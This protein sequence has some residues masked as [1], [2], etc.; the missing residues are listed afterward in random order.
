[1]ASVCTNYARSFGACEK[2]SKMFV[3]IDVDSPKYCLASN[4]PENW[5]HLHTQA[6]LVWLHCTQD[7]D[8]AK[9]M[10]SLTPTPTH[11]QVVHS[12]AHNHKHDWTLAQ[13]WTEKPTDFSW[14]TNGGPKRTLAVAQHGFDSR[15]T[16]TTNTRHDRIFNMKLGSRKIV[17]LSLFVCACLTG[18]AHDTCG[19]TGDRHSTELPVVSGWHVCEHHRDSWRSE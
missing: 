3:R 8:T 5:A 13:Y 2:K 6:D 19:Y 11:N 16:T 17:F 9:Q 18:L 12:Y 10:S 15:R 14:A 1:M 4:Q 7:M